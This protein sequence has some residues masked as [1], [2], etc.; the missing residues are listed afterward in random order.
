[1]SKLCNLGCVGKISPRD[2]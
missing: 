1:M 2:F